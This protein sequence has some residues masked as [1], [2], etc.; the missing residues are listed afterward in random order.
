MT[1]YLEDR[2]EEKVCVGPWFQFIV[3][4]PRYL[5][6]AMHC[7]G[8]YPPSH[9]TK[10]NRDGKGNDLRISFEDTHHFPKPPSTPGSSS[11]CWPSARVLGWAWET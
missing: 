7:G 4:R 11:D 9:G 10:G 1:E 3:T 8:G 6:P 5:G 2:L